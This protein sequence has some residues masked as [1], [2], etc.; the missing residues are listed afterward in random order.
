MLLV[1]SIWGG[2]EGKGGKDF[3]MCQTLDMENH[4]ETQG[5]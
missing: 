1:K 5:V 2:L 4:M 3:S